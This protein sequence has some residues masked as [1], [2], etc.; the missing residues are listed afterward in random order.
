MTLKSLA[1]SD[2]DLMVNVT[3]GNEKKKKSGEPEPGNC[4][5]QD[6]CRTISS[7]DPAFRIQAEFHLY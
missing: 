3:F 1:R 2:Q 4:A 5:R 7:K 6:K